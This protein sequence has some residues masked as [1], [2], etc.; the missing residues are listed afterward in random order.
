MDAS[1]CLLRRR[2]AR[3]W[4]RRRRRGREGQGRR[5]ARV[6]TWAGASWSGSGKWTRTWSGRFPPTRR[7]TPTGRR[8][9]GEGTLMRIPAVPKMSHIAFIANGTPLAGRQ[10]CPSRCPAEMTPRAAAP[11]QARAE[12]LYGPQPLGGVLPGHEFYRGLH[13]HA[14]GGGAGLLEPV[15]GGGEFAAG[16]LHGGHDR[17]APRPPLLPENL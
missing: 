8:P 15:P 10:P 11:T 4:R 7:W 3:V 1:G 14:H 2:G 17:A 13:A 5:R 6:L 9:C 16:L 12:C